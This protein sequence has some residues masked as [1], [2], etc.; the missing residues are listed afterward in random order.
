MADSPSMIHRREVLRRAAILLGGV[1]SAP[2]IAG[3][4]ADEPRAWAATP[5]E[6]WVPRTLT[7][8]QSELVA[9]VA[10]H[11]IPATDT[12]GA[13]AVGVHRFIDVLLTDFY[14]VADRDR[15]VAGVDGVDARAR[16]R[17]GR[18]F[19][20]CTH[21]QQHALLDELDGA[22]YAAP[23]ML[24]QQSAPDTTGVSAAVAAEL[25]SPWFWRRMKELTLTG[26]YTSQVGATQELRVSPWGA[27][28]DIPYSSV[29]RSWS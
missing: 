27:Y 28:R 6:R 19:A 17:H 9:T 18:S 21:D 16:Q 2:T 12:P 14:P 5:D 26:Y 15:F 3:V 7:A 4:L 20:R 13:R 23:G 11:I 24:A 25:R 10:E 1:I 29:G 8:A 22:A